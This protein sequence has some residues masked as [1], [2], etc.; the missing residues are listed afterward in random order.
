SSAPNGLDTPQSGSRAETPQRGQLVAPMAAAV[1]TPLEPTMPV[2]PKARRLPRISAAL[3]IG[4]V[5]LVIAGGV[6]G[7]LSLLAHFGVLSTRRGAITR[8]V[9]RGGTWTDDFSQDPYSFIPN[10]A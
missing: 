3:L 6:L 10:Q 8:T 1:P 2:Q 9:V 5:V 7:S 4:L